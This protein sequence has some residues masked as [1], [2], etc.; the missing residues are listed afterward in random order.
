MRKILFVLAAMSILAASVF[1]AEPGAPSI[2]K[3][4]DGEIKSVEGEVVSLAEAMPADKY[5]FSP[6]GE[7]FEGV[8]TFSQQMTHIAAVNYMV[9]AAALGEKNPSEA[10][11]GE[12]GPES[13]KGKEAVV[14]YLKDSF[15]YA[16]KA[17]A[18]MTTA[19]A[20]DM[21]PPPFGKAKTPRM[22]ALSIVPWH[23]FDHYGQSAVYARMCGIVPPA[24]RQ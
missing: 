2:G 1:A 18:A 19:N 24:S 14:K 21:M 16:H 15:A 7:K 3:I 13:I 11:P 5:D 4:L 8:R 6:K 23:S 22:A 12:N 20:L 9:S 17:A 10:G